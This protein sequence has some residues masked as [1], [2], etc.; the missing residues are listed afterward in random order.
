MAI[1]SKS[2]NLC[3]QQLED[4]FL[5]T[6]DKAHKKQKWHKVHQVKNIIIYMK[7]RIFHKERQCFLGD[8]Q[9][10]MKK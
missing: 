6:Q 2:G 3:S 10:A 7:N 9:M 1:L 5:R 4:V 8:V